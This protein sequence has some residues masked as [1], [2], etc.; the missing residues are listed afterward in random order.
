MAAAG[1]RLQIFPALPNPEYL[2][3]GAMAPALQ[4]SQ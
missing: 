1:A 3:F 4:A 2:I